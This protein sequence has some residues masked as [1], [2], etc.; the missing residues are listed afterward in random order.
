M[1]RSGP[2]RALAGY[3][4]AGAKHM[5]MLMEHELGLTEQQVLLS[6][7]LAAAA[8]TGQQLLQLAEQAP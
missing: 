3:S 4:L 2:G 5:H 8:S 6:L 7:H 1:F